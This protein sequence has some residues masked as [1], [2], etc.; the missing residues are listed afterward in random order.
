VFVTFQISLIKVCAFWDITLRV[1]TISYRRFEKTHRSYRPVSINLRNNF[2][3]GFYTLEGGSY[4]LTQ[5]VDNKIPVC[6]P[7]Y[8]LVTHILLTSHRKPEITHFNS[9]FIAVSFIVRQ[10]N[11]CSILTCIVVLK[12]GAYVVVRV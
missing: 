9:L 5:N 11:C 4:R 8:P 2:V 12:R 7:Q 3:P 10:F 6:D 1:I